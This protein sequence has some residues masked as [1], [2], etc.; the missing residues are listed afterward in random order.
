MNKK[1]KVLIIVFSIFLLLGGILWGGFEYLKYSSKYPLIEFGKIKRLIPQDSENAASR[2][3]E[4]LEKIEK[5]KNP[6]RFKSKQVDY[7]VNYI[8]VLA[9]SE[10]KDSI[11]SETDFLNRLWEKGN[12]ETK[13]MVKPYI[14]YQKVIHASSI[15]E[16]KAA[17]K[18]F[19]GIFGEFAQFENKTERFGLLVCNALDSICPNDSLRDTIFNKIKSNLVNTKFEQ[20]DKQIWKRFMLS[21]CY[22]SEYKN[23]QGKNCNPDT[24]QYLV[25][26]IT[27]VLPVKTYSNFE[28]EETAMGISIIGLVFEHVNYY[29]KSGNKEEAYQV[30]ADLTLKNP[31]RYFDYYSSTYEQIEGKKFSDEDWFA[32]L[33]EFM[34]KVPSVQYKSLE[35]SILDL[36]QKRDRWL[37]LDFWGTWCPPCIKQLPEI[38]VFYE[39]NKNILDVFT[40]SKG[41]KNLETFITKNNYTFPVADVETIEGFD[42]TSYPTKLLISPGG[43]YIKVPH[44]YE[45]VNFVK[46]ITRLNEIN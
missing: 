21:Y 8:E 17:A 10:C 12:A 38:Q 1:N 43:N 42:I 7:I 37:L 24:L 46:K 39:N 15:A 5:K 28:F 35:G 11:E 16:T 22:Y 31:F 44:T 9:I 23:H 34:P 36:S 33:A 2:Y 6:Q 41:S 19:A 25:S 26:Q 32:S 18:E 4:L 13:E 14:Y 3:F 20:E 30:L 40:I 45:W 29:L 27:E